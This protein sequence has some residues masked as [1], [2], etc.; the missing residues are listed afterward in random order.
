MSDGSKKNS[1]N[2][3]HFEDAASLLLRGG[4]LIS[5]SCPDC[6]GVQIKFKNDTICVNCGKRHSMDNELRTKSN[7]P[8]IQQGAKEYSQSITDFLEIEKLLISR[9]GHLIMEIKNRNDLLIENQQ[10]DLIETY[11]RIIKKIRKLK[12]IRVS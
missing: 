3:P 4:S 6:S 2:N 1:S 8:S 12:Q 5:E 7:Q 10:A 9:I 11:L